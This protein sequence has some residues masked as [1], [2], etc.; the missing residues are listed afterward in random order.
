[1]LLEVRFEGEVIRGIG[2]G[3][4]GGVRGRVVRLSLLFTIHNCTFR[5]SVHPSFGFLSAFFD[6]NSS[7][8]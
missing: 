4:R 3:G 7:D 2:G 6:M 1:M 5:I 8:T